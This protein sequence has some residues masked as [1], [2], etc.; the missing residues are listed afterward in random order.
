MQKNQINL[1]FKSRL[2]QIKGISYKTEEKLLKHFGTFA[3]IYNASFEE[4]QKV[5]NKSIA[6]KIKEN[7]DIIARK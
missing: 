4:L 3:N 7:L 6:Q 5:T 2:I 1:T